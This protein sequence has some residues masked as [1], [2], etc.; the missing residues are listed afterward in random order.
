MK[1]TTKNTLKRR[2][3]AGVL[4]LSAAALIAWPPTPSRALCAD[5]GGDG[6]VLASDA[7]ATLA[8]A[9]SGQYMARADIAVAGRPD[10]KITAAD[11]LATMFS[12]VS[13]VVP[14]CAAGGERTV[15]ATTASCDFATGG[16]ARIDAATHDVLEH[17]LGAFAAD[18]VVRSSAGRVFVLDRFRGSSVVELDA[19]GD[20]EPLWG[21]SV[22]AG[23]NPHDIAVASDEKAYV[24]RYDAVSLA[25]IDPSKGPGCTGFVT[26][27]IDLSP[28]ADA[29]GVPEMDQMLLLG[30]KLFVAIQ[31]L[32]RKAFFRPAAN[33]A[34]VVIDTVTDEVMDVIELSIENPFVESKGLVYLPQNDRIYVGG[35]GDL[36]TDLE[37]GGI[38]IINP[39]TM[40][41]EGVAMT[42]AELGG[43]L[44]DFSLLGT[45]R[46]FAV[47]AGSNFVADLVE[48]DLS[49]RTRSAPIASSDQL[50]SDLET[51]ERGLVWL[52]DR[53]CFEPGLRVF[54]GGGSGEITASPIYPGLTPFNFIFVR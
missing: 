51:T 34:L 26:G 22:G 8:L 15:A 27:H 39:A 4:S 5:S 12:A 9:A 21:C 36:F 13:G 53:N 17:R 25:V 40:S 46:G 42:G 10:G 29:D 48:I 33:G 44:T 35:P 19:E 2:L 45:G 3:R 23:S 47:V 37:D 11:A 28:Y 32:D 16:L 14:D 41:S 6:R 43:D 18:S 7:L 54:E 49:A 31:R 38:E 24:S 50:L 52:A 30:D 1:K 20:L